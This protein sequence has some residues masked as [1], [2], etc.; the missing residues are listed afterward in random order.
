M[1]L[2]SGEL[3]YAFLCRV[4]IKRAV[5]DLDKRMVYRHFLYKLP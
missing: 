1:D 5:L 3:W 4:E 2:H